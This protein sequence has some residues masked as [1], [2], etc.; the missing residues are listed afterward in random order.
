VILLDTHVLVWV[1]TVPDKLSHHARSTIEAA[2]ALAISDITLW[3]VALLARR[4]RLRIAGGVEQHLRAIA[5]SVQVLPLS[6]TVAAGVAALP[7]EFAT[8]DP[9][10]QIIYATA[11]AHDVRLV[12][13]DQQLR[14]Y[15][16]AVVL[17]D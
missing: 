12:S 4:G 14:T 10:D 9:A 3:E 17:W 5:A 8:R 7:S 13:A 6:A 16:P 2:P 15:D 1:R 11:I